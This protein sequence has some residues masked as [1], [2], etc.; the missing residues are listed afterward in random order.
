MAAIT[1][2]PRRVRCVAVASGRGFTAVQVGDNT[3]V[4]CYCSPNVG[5]DRFLQLLDD[6]ESLMGK[7]MRGS[8]QGAQPRL[9]IGGDFNAKSPYWGS[10]SSNRRGEIM[11]DWA[12]Q[13][14]LCLINSGGK[15]TCIRPQGSSHI[16][17]TWASAAA[18]EEIR[19]WRVQ[20]ETE[21]LSDHLYVSFRIGPEDKKKNKNI[22]GHPRWSTHTYDMGLLQNILSWKCSEENRP[23]TAEKFAGWFAKTMTEAS[24]LAARRVTT[25]RERRAVYW[26]DGTIADARRRCVR[27]RRSWTRVKACPALN[28]EARIL[29]KRAKKELR[30]LISRAKTRAWEELLDS[31][32]EDP[33][34]LPYKLVLGRLSR[35][36]G[37]TI[38]W[39]DPELMGPLVDSLFPD[40]RTHSP[41][42]CCPEFQWDPHLQI[43][44]GEVARVIKQARKGGGDPAPGPDGIRLSVWRRVPQCMVERLAEMYSQCLRE[45][46]F[47]RRWKRARL[48]LLPKEGNTPGPGLMPKARPICLLDEVGKILERVLVRR[49]KTWMAEEE[50]ADLSPNQYGFREGKS[51]T[52]ALAAVVG[53]VRTAT[54]RGDSVVA[55]SIDIKNAF[56]T[57]PWPVIRKALRD[58]GCPTYLCRIIDSYL[59]DRSIEYCTAEG[60]IVSRPVTAGVPQGSIL[61]PLLWNIAFDKIPGF[62]TFPGCQV[63]CYADDTLVLAEGR[64]PH[65]AAARASLQ[66]SALVRAIRLLGLSVATDKSEA[67][68]FRARGVRHPRGHTVG[69]GG[70]RINTKGPL[71]YLGVLLD[72]R[73][74]FDDH[75]R[76]MGEKTLAITRGLC[77]LM[78][79]LKGPRERK[80]KL[81]ANVISSVILY[82]API[83]ADE[84]SSSRR[85]IQYIQKVQKTY[86]LRVISA[87]RTT[88]FEAACALARTPPLELVAQARRRIFERVAD[89][90][91]RNDWTRRQERDI[92]EQET[93]LLRRQWLMR[94]RASGAPGERTREALGPSF[95]SWMGR[96]WGCISYHMTQ[97]L[98]GHGCF[99][100]YLH[101]I[102]KVNIPTCWFCGDPC[103]SPDHTLTDCGEW[104]TA[105]LPLREMLREGEDFS[106]PNIVRIIATDREAW[107][108]FA[109]FAAQVMRSKEAK[110]RARLEASAEARTE[111]SPPSL[112]EFVDE[113][114]GEE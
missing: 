22:K 83:W 62:R 4:S 23:L 12:A 14:G 77:R 114:S 57:L 104:E 71:K 68:L 72:S 20:D 101:R 55:I 13:M 85:L 86:A 79:N 109:N 52:D 105:R 18:A 59:H 89:L 15:P 47:P 24:D 27:A 108:A 99:A 28:V 76:K 88:S 48:F 35:A 7:V 9:V 74:G 6:L 31:V 95:E 25:Q 46:Y 37:G 19:D 60:G 8:P 63:I 41:E 80:R 75:L 67:I 64:D 50:G 92:R 51:T 43:E 69:V 66:V 96:K 82:A 81:Y 70:E 33:W 34:G 98:T 10:V 44:V 73:L 90:R 3:L 30:S 56:N 2:N 84:L 32:E 93:L 103:D 107:A 106:L 53:T 11:Q 100:T 94:M 29:Y 1:W 16:D 58:R 26:W 110:E 113:I 87:Y 38:S 61:G 91:R 49:L 54:T 40:G 5:L 39:I 21:F 78:P 97:L 36:A 112:V 17:T 102:G 42:D 111:G 65:K 45:G